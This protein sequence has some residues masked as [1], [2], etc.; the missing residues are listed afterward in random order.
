MIYSPPRKVRSGFTLLEVMLAIA[1]ALA[2]SG[3]MFAFMNNLMLRRDQA[4][5]YVTQSQAS[6][7]IIERLETD[8]FA[9]LVAAGDGAGI[10]GGANRI[11][12]LTRGVTPPMLGDLASVPLGDLQGSEFVFDPSTHELRGGRFEAGATPKLETIARLDR[13]RFRY[14]NGRSWSSS[15]NS[16]SAGSLPAAVEI[17]IWFHTGER[18]EPPSE[19][20]AMLPEDALADPILDELRA[21]EAER[22]AMLDEAQERE[23]RPMSAP[24][25]L[26]V[27]V[28]PDGATADIGGRRS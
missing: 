7:A 2:L 15:F 28:I 9:A 4:I 22:L 16:Q 13:V 21:E 25:R 5:E 18:E 6:G 19:L 8:L 12:V 24:D 20:E 23:D 11:R 10:D 26:R 1:L 17:A 14:H 27:I 3:G